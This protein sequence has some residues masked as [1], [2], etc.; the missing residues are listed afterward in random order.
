MHINSVLLLL[1]PCFILVS[2]QSFNAKQRFRYL[3]STCDPHIDWLNSMGEDMDRLI[4]A[5]IIHSTIAGGTGRTDLTA[6][7]FHAFWGWNSP[8]T[9]TLFYQ[10]MKEYL[11]TRP[12][13]NH[14]VWCGIDA[15]EPTEVD[16]VT[17]E[18]H[19]DP[20][21]GPVTITNDIVAPDLCHN[22]EGGALEAISMDRGGVGRA[23]NLG[24][25]VVLCSGAFGNRDDPAVPPIVQNIDRTAQPLGKSLDH[26][27]SIAGIFLHEL[28]HN[29]YATEDIAKRVGAAIQ[30]ATQLPITKVLDNAENWMYYALAALLDQNAWVLGVAQPLWAWGPYAPYAAAIARREQD[31][32]LNAAVPTKE[33]TTSTSEQPRDVRALRVVER[34]LEPRQE[35]LASMPSAVTTMPPACEYVKYGPPF[36]CSRPASDAV[37]IAT[38]TS[39]ISSELARESIIPP[40]KNGA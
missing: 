15:F 8:S 26:M 4:N 12:K 9:I 14:N 1:A 16:W 27:V 3:D 21:Q 28:T 36:R 11:S 17:R 34:Q 20:E 7:T 30:L 24:H 18:G 6:A 10:N 22:T 2:A 39:I 31:H 32:L 33:N 38:I 37:P 29:L 25:I 40:T 13:I 23:R 19:Y 5:A 35:N